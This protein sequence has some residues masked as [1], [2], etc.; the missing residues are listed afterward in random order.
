MS[1]GTVKWFD[2][3]KKFG[4]ITQDDGE[5]IF[6]H[7]SAILGPNELEKGDRVIFDIVETQKG[8][9][10]EC[11]RRPQKEQNEFNGFLSFKNEA[12]KV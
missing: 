12:S 2:Q 9:K 11:I 10:A 4:F 3:K 5:E 8:Q 6:F 7:S 1:K